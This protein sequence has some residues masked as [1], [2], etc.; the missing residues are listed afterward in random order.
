MRS[1]EQRKAG[2]AKRATLAARCTLPALSFALI[3]AGC[4]PK[5]KVV[6][7]A[8]ALPLTGDIAALGQGL[9]RACILA[10]ED[11]NAKGKFQGFKV[12]MVAFDDRSDPREAVGVANRI[13]SDPSI[14]AVV[15]HFNSGC[16]IPASLVYA[17]AHMPMISPAA[18]NPKL[19]Q[20][21]LD[22]SWIWPRNVFRVNTTDDVQ[23]PYAADFAFKTRGWKRAAI[24]HD[25]TAYGQGVA[26]EF[27]KHYE[28]LGGV[29]LSFDG[30]T[31]ADKDFNA[32]LTRIHEQ[33]PQVL[34]WGGD[35]AG[36]GLIVRQAR[37]SGIQSPMIL[38]EA[39]F[40]PEY[41][42]VAGTSAEGTY[43]TFLGAPA[44]LLPSAQAMVTAYKARFPNDELK[45]YDHWGYE[46]MSILLD[47]IQQVGPD[48]EK[49]LQALPKIRHEGVLG[50][51][52]FDEKGD[53]L[54]RTITIFEV[55]N[56]QFV[57]LK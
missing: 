28:K 25:K 52:Q 8:A 50:V 44:S 5:E 27:R 26:D 54:N 2:S 53:T 33:N 24:I 46:A 39:N 10:L 15:G 56:G 3:L 21:Q 34:Y 38:S 41:L 13:V 43:V 19:T 6:R 22:P 7:V 57:P 51:T 31:V 23:G 16:S 17:K 11:A 20:Q 45:A 42:R 55:K 49:I 40:D 12:E 14:V 30:V 47:L 37:Q 4:G 18:S 9:K 36:G 48:R 35:Y 1:S 32:L 29:V